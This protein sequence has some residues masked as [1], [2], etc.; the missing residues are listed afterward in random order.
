MVSPVKH[1]K[2]LFWFLRRPALMPTFAY[3]ARN[4]FLPHP[5][6]GSGPEALAWCQERAIG[7]SQAAER[8]TG[9]PLRPV[10]ELYPDV[11]AGAEA[12]ARECPFGMGG[13]GAL[14]LLHHLAMNI[15]ARRAVETGVAYGWSSLALLLGLRDDGYLVS[16]DMPYLKM[17]NDDFVGCAVPDSLHARWK[18]LRT[19]DRQGLEAALT[20]AAPIDLCHYDSDK[21]YRGRMWSYPL[22]WD[23]LRPGG[24]FLSDDISDDTAFRDFAA[25]LGRE[26]VV[27][28]VPDGDQIKYAGVIPK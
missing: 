10:R 22:L 1:L 15:G 17:G 2:T 21:T 16:I 18:L 27:V 25:T 14:D 23:A 8:L 5:M 28:A 3:L 11:F 20:E 4:K 26:P 12:R 24:L 19:S 9:K 13:A 6:E 7:V